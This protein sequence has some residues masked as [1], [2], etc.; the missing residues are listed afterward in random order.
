MTT[1][2]QKTIYLEIPLGEFERLHAEI[3]TLQQAHDHLLQVHGALLARL[4][5]IRRMAQDITDAA[6]A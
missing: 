4:R 2:E 5:A 6:D 1:P 3:K